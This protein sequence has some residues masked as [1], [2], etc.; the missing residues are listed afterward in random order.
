MADNVIKC[1]IKTVRD[2]TCD[3]IY[4]DEVHPQ[5]DRAN[6]TVLVDLGNGKTAAMCRWC[7]EDWQRRH[8]EMQILEAGSGVDTP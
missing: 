3:C 5:C 1:R 6:P 7:A 4:I 8:P 2:S